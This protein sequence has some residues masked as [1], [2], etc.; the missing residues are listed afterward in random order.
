LFTAARRFGW[1][2]AMTLLRGIALFSFTM[3]LVG[4]CRLGVPGAT[5]AIISADLLTIAV[6]LA[7]MRRQ[8]R[9]EWVRPTAANLLDMLHYGARYWIGAISNQTNFRVG[10]LILGFF[11]S[12]DQI[13]VYALAVGLAIQMQILPDALITALVPRTASDAA[14]RKDLVARC[15]RLTTLASLML[16]AIAVL[17]ARP[18]MLLAFPRSFGEAAPLLQVL[19]LAFFLRTVGKSLEPYLVGTNRP[20]L[21][22]LSV[23]TGTVVNMVGVLVLLP[24]IGLY[25]PAWA[26]VLNY[27]A[28][29]ILLVAGFCRLAGMDL[30]ATWL[31]RWSDF[32][33]VKGRMARLLPSTA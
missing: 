29:S 2:S 24:R 10:I 25:G 31:P 7:V 21:I 19:A 32:A 13:G 3:L 33:F 28:S 12:K 23:L 4:G 6:S 11:A 14:G 8:F 30:L 1:F 17:L 18:I 5:A 20:G 16:L 9:L 22:S 15:A 26:M 27:L